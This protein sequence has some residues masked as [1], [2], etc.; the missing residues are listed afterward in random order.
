MTHGQWLC[1][2][3]FGCRLCHPLGRHMLCC[4]LLDMVTAAVGPLALWA[5]QQKNKDVPPLTCTCGV[6]AGAVYKYDVS[7]GVQ[8]MYALV[9]RVKTRVGDRAG[10]PARCRH[11]Y[12]AA[13]SCEPQRCAALQMAPFGPHILGV[14]GYGHVGDG[15]GIRDL[16]LGSGI[17]AHTLFSVYTKC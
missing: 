15:T 6:H 7:V 12:T 14:V 2:C 9:E 10:R 16:G 4:R 17:S 8:R 3:L 5:C 11:F 13:C 1:P